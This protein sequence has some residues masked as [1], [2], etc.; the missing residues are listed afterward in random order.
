M[1]E[2]TLQVFNIIVKKK[3]H[4]HSCRHVRSSFGVPP[5]ASRGRDVVQPRPGA[6]RDSRDSR[7]VPWA[8][9]KLVEEGPR[10][11]CL[12]LPQHWQY[13]KD[14]SAVNADIKAML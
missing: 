13:H 10:V 7:S 3:W 5:N 12:A 2:D 11:C 8:E 6:G 1:M 14:I 4:V 9:M